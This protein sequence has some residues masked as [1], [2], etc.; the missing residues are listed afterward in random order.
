MMSLT[1][2]E[3][4]LTGIASRELNCEEIAWFRKAEQLSAEK[5]QL[6]LQSDM[7]YER[8]QGRVEG[9]QQG[10]VDIAKNLLNLGDPIEKIIAVTGLTREELEKLK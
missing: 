8:Q 1:S 6:D 7:V 3:M 2:E 10:R 5:Y 9:L 4:E